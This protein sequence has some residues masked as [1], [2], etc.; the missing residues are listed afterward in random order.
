MTHL[1]APRSSVSSL[2]DLRTSVSRFLVTTGALVLF[3]L[4]LACSGAEGGTEAEQGFATGPTML[5]GD[6]CR[7]CHGGPSSQYPDAP[8]WTVAG[9]VFES[10]DSDVGASGVK[11]LIHDIT[12]NTLTL[13]TNGVGNFYTNTEL[14]FPYW[15]TLEKDGVMVDMP[16]PP[17]SGGCNACHNDP[18][19]AGAPG[20][21]FVPEDGSYDSM[22][23]CS[24]DGSALMVGVTPYDCTP[25]ACVDSDSDAPARCL[26]ACATDDDC[27]IGACD[28]ANCV[29]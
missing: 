27:A 11:V 7:S 15:V 25:F 1:P 21:L 23:Q 18:A 6:N 2:W 16:A 4:P 28:D 20:R 26:T 14:D 19:V 9:T 13:T 29:E 22:G 10:A 12:G 3:A 5:P 8:A 24:D 17:P